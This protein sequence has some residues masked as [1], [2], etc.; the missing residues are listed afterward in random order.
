[1]SPEIRHAGIARRM[2]VEIE[3]SVDRSEVGKGLER[4]RKGRVVRSVEAQ[5]IPRSIDEEQ[6]RAE[7]N[8]IRRERG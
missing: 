1:M 3:F 2:G 6:V 8:E 7:S 4:T 5:E